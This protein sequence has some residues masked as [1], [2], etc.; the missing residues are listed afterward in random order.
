M[1]TTLTLDKDVAAA[2]ERLR[3]QRPAS[4]KQLVNDALRLGVQQMSAPAPRSGR[5]FRTRPLSLGRCLG[6]NVDNVAEALAL[7]ERESF[8]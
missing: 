1:R 4:F 5:A 6:G 2:L 3:K 8:K 7:A